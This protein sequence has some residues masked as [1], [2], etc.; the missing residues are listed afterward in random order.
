MYLLTLL[1]KSR[2][3]KTVEFN[4]PP[5]SQEIEIAMAET[6]DAVNFDISRK[7]LEDSD[8]EELHED[9]LETL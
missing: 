6:P 5:T 4:Q 8:F 3:V 9:D 7:P 1:N 2:V